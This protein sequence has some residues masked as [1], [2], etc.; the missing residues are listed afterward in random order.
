[1]KGDGIFN[2]EFELQA[3]N[4]MLSKVFLQVRNRNSLTLFVF[5]FN[6]IYMA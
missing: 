4:Y 5:S 6:M 3:F 1:M 2:A